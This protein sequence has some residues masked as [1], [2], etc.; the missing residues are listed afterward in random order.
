MRKKVQELRKRGEVHGFFGRTS[1]IRN[2]GVKFCP[3]KCVRLSVKRNLDK[4]G[5][6]TG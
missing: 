2:L 1:K 5:E 3:S 6:E 4:P